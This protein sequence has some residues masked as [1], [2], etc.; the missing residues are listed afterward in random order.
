MANQKITT[1]TANTTPLSTDI[2]P[3]V[4]DPA[5]TPTTQK[6]TLGNALK[7]INDLTVESSPDTSADYLL[8]YDTSSSTAK[9]V[10]PTSLNTGLVTLTGTQTLTNKTLTTPTIADLSNMTHNHTSNATGG[11]IERG[12]TL[13]AI[14]NGG[15]PADS[16]TYYFGLPFRAVTQTTA[17]TRRVYIPKAGTL[18]RADISI[19]NGA[20]TV[21]T[22]ETST[23]YFRL[24]NTTDT[25]LSSAI[26]NNQASEASSYINVTGLSTAVAAGNYFE[27]KW[28][29]PNWATNPTAPVI[30]V[31]LFIET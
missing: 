1:L 15:T 19:T 13:F 20:G 10:T 4:D 2:I 24:N 29:T 25:T 6:I 30:M 3:I 8:L 7:V 12:Y 26:V 9:K 17:G 23:I 28:V 11:K 16:T 5:G 27:I 31:N 22:A 21:G 14:G 18:T